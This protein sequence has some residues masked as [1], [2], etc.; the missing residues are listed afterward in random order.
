MAINNVV[1]L[2]GGVGGAKLAYGLAQ[3]LGPDALTIVVNTGD[4]FWHYGLRICPD[5]DTILY[6]LGERV[7]K[8][9]G[10]GVA[11]DTTQTL[12]A[13]G[14]LGEDTWF[15]LGDLDLATHLVRT[16][17]LREGATLTDVVAR[18]KRS[19]NVGHV[20][21]PMTDDEVATVVETA[22]WGELAFQTYFVR[23]RWQPKVVQL[24]Y[25]GAEVATPSAAV[26]GA[27]AEADAVVIGPS[28]PW[29][30]IAPILAMDTLRAA[31]V[32]R[33]VP[34]VAV[35]P[36]VGGQALKGPT[37]KIMGELGITPSAREVALY[38]EDV[39]NGFV[40]DKTDEPLQL[41]SLRTTKQQTVMRTDR[42]KILL[43]EALMKKL[44]SWSK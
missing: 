7:D 14:R 21:L 40:Y 24:H 35:T 3:V 23:H 30:S 42:D 18:L 38:Y 19:L 43:A 10:W 5:I 22:E 17:M 8:R 11:N 2:V 4:D 6:T 12:D 33:D 27:I 36:I 39:I 15:R 32:A 44:V 1:L 25:R 16:S 37:A 29:L 34:R 13:L 28:N 9:Q 31:L 26:L 20:V 41:R